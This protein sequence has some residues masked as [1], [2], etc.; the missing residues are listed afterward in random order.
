M[1]KRR[2]RA[3]P[4]SVVAAIDIGLAKAACVIAQTSGDS[5][6][7]EDAAILGVGQNGGRSSETLEDVEANVRAALEAA[8]RMAG[9]EVETAYVVAPGRSIRARRLAVDLALSNGVVTVEDI[10]D[11]M[12]AAR[13][14]VLEGFLPLSMEPIRWTLDAEPMGEAPVGLYGDDLCAEFLELAVRESSAANVEAVLANCGV[15]VSGWAPG[16]AAAHRMTKADQGMSRSNGVG[17]RCRSALPPTKN[18]KHDE[19]A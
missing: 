14:A 2:A 1:T 8:E 6:D 19:I 3:R 7:P 12:T 9:L 11:C 5:D 15:T 17:V 13:A 18:P 4:G 16:P 10:R